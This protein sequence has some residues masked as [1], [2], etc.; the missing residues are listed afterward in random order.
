MSSL[1]VSAQGAAN[2]EITIPGDKSISHR[3]AIFAAIACG[4]SHIRGFLF[5][6]D[7]LAT[8]EAL[9]ALG[10]KSDIDNNTLTIHG[11][12]LEGLSLAPLINL[13]NSG[14]SMRLFCGL[15]AGQCFS[16]ELTGDASLLSRPMGRVFKPL[17][18][19]GA[20][21]QAKLDEFAPIHIQGKRPLDN[22]NYKM[23]IA[24]AQIK[25]AIMLAALYAD[26]PCHIHEVLPSRNHSELLLPMFG[27][28]VT[29]TKKVITVIP[30]KLIATDINVPG[31][32][33]SA[34]FFI[35]AG[36]I[37]PGADVLIKDVGVNVTRCGILN[38]LKRMGAMLTVYPKNNHNS[39]Y[40][41]PLADIHI[42]YSPLIA[43]NISSEEIPSLIDELPIIFIAAAHAQGTTI[44]TGAEELRVKES[45]RIATMEQ[46]MKALGYDVCATKDGMVIHGGI[47]IPPLNEDIKLSSHGD[48]R[49]AMALA[50]AANASGSPVEISDCANIATSFPEFVPTAESLGM[51]ISEHV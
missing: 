35:V 10:V 4:T 12:G 42:R 48:H 5:A 26:A 31:D 22:I 30:K 40:A 46:G 37:T 45:D 23:P 19:M 13:G 9:N 39:S 21:F 7:T 17:R 36:A 1:I 38:V 43:T 41:E 20:I 18:Q 15:L 49:I 27:G 32:I 25:T 16:S 28:D 8:I 47:K 51:G 33:S 24:S 2:G 29:I 3:C 44:V 14:T 11:V 6:Q 34:A 50:I